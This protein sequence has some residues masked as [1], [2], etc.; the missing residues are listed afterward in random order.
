MKSKNLLVVAGLALVL[1]AVGLTGCSPSD[2]AGAAAALETVNVSSQQAGIWVTGQGKV[3]T[4]PDVATVRLGIEAQEQ[5]V[6]E[7]Q[8]RAAEAMNKVEDALTG[9]GVAA[10]DIQTQYFSVHQ[11]T[12]WDRDTEQETVIGFRV[13][14]TVA[15]KVRD[16]DRVGEVL[17]AVIAAG[18]DLTR[19]DGISFSVDDPTAFHE[20]AR[21]EAMQDAR[22]KAE[23]LARLAGISLGQA[24]YI[25]ESSFGV[26][27]P[28]PMSG[29]M[30]SFDEA[31]VTSI[32]PGELDITLSVQVIYSIP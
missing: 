29:A 16:I 2:T 12:R 6:A 1:T 18:G 4:A 27:T 9:A 11:V 10:K 23:Q 21:E 15:A 8:A 14:N 7:A 30:R 17:D 3:S 28:Y 20:Q 22:D 19:I 26:P 32:S 31:A 13:V 25:S 5:T 24:T